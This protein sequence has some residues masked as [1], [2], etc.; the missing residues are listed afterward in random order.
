M[1]YDMGPE[2]ESDYRKLMLEDEEDKII[3]DYFA[4]KEE[5]LKGDYKG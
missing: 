1:K 3:A 4:K 5:N 2:F